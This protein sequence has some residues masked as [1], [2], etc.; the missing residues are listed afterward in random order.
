MNAICDSCGYDPT[1]VRASLRRTMAECEDCGRTL[2]DECLEEM[3]IENGVVSEPDARNI[4]I[5]SGAAGFLFRCEES[6]QDLC[7]ECFEDG[8]E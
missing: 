3:A 2:C 6:C 1:V 4:I 7:P 5:N 8:A